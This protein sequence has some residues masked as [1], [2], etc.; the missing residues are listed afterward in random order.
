MELIQRFLNSNFMLGFSDIAMLAE[1]WW[2]LITDNGEEDV[3]TQVWAGTWFDVLVGVIQIDNQ[4][5]NST[6]W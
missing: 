1:S 4:Y 2:Y 5:S 6:P 3:S